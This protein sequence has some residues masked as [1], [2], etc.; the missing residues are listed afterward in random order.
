MECC[1]AGPRQTIGEESQELGIQQLLELW[2][3]GREGQRVL[4]VQQRPRVDQAS[5]ALALVV[6]SRP[7][8]E[9]GISGSA[10]A[11]GRGSVWN[12]CHYCSENDPVVAQSK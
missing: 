9:A 10:E 11:P 12:C 8:A 2:T 1:K 7:G 4:S 3:A 5:A 6:S